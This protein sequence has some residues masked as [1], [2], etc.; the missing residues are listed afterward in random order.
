MLIPINELAPETL[1]NLAQ[2]FVLREGT[3]YGL[4]E[5]ALVDK[6]DAVIAQLRSG[7]AVLLYSELHESVNIV[8][9]E[10]WHAMQGQDEADQA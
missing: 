2:D 7:E 3:D 6:V 8:S 4:Q 9:R 10:A 1:R 5:T